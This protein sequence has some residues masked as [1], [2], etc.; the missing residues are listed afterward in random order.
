[1]TVH[2]RHTTL[3]AK[4]PLLVSTGKGRTCYK[5]CSPQP[6]HTHRSFLASSR[7]SSSSCP[8]LCFFNSPASGAFVLY[9]NCILAAR[10][11]LSFFGG[12]SS[13]FWPFHPTPHLQCSTQSLASRYTY[14]PT[15]LAQLG[16]LVSLVGTQSLANDLRSRPH[17][18]PVNQSDHNFGRPKVQPPNGKTSD[19]IVTS[20]APAF[21]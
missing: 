15:Y 19:W 2:T 9:K 10:V 13:C 1:M 21:L 3:P 8:L 20:F 11:L 18:L 14:L 17:L 4:T 5:T 7:T 12:F 6:A 16:C